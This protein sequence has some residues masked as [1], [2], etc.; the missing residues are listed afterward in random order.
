MTY[1]WRTTAM[2]ALGCSSTPVDVGSYVSV[3]EDPW[4]WTE[5]KTCATGPQL[6]IVG[7]WTGYTFG[8]RS[9]SGSDAVRL[10]IHHANS[11]RVCGTLTLGREAPAWP[12]IIDANVAY[13]PELADSLQ[14]SFGAYLAKLEGVPRT[15]TRSSVALPR[16]LFRASYAQWRDWCALQKPYRCEGVATEEYYCVPASGPGGLFPRV[17]YIPDVG[18]VTE[19]DGEMLTVDCGKAMLCLGGPCTCTASQCVAPALWGS[20]YELEFRGDTAAGAGMVLTRE[21]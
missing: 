17:R 7:T 21:H 1:L 5:E 16:V 9:P 12:S 8:E 10:V 6:P 2:L 18:C 4:G 13:P 15:L 20:D 19:Y 11:Q 3:G 14:S